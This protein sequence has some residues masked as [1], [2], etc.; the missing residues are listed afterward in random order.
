MIFCMKLPILGDYLVILSWLPWYL[1]SSCILAFCFYSRPYHYIYFHKTVWHIRHSATSFC[2]KWKCIYAAFWSDN[3]HV[4]TKRHAACLK[5]DWLKGLQQHWRTHLRFSTWASGSQ[6]K[7]TFRK[8]C[9]PF[10]WLDL[11][12]LSF[13][14]SQ[15]YLLL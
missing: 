1:C 8:H 14:I 10:A 13:L 9:L 5:G 7:V 4:L 11:L 15:N 3:S 12:W 6:S 2:C